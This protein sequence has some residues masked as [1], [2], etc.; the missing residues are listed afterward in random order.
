MPSCQA[1]ILVRLLHR[2]KGCYSSYAFIYRFS[3]TC[4]TTSAIRGNGYCTDI[5][6]WQESVH[7]LR[8]AM[9][10]LQGKY[11]GDSHATQ[12]PFSVGL[13]SLF[14]VSMFVRYECFQ[15]SR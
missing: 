6:F 14:L 1:R 5:G 7:Q 2:I 3:S 8:F 13:S 4:W 10:R 12:L 9:A 11:P 15:G